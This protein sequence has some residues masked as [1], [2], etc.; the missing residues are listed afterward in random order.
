VVL[1]LLTRSSQE[2]TQAKIDHFGLE[3][4]FQD[5]VEITPVKSKKGKHPEAR[6][7][8]HRLNP[9]SESE[10]YFIGD[11]LEDVEVADPV[12]DSYQLNA[13]GIFL[14]R[15]KGEFP[16][17]TERYHQVRSLDEVPRII[18]K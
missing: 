9:S 11:R 6:N 1:A 5:R 16:E 12:R 3:R 14:Q 17:G 2:Y 8:I 18:L 4:Y 10:I 15:S 7:L 13:N